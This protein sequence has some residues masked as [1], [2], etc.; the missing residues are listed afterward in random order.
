MLRSEGMKV[1]GHANERMSKSVL[2]LFIIIWILFLMLGI[3]LSS[4]KMLIIITSVMAFI[5][6]FH[7]VLRI[8]ACLTAKPDPVV[9]LE[10]SVW[11]FYMVLVPIFREAHMVEGLMQALQKIEYPINR[12]EIFMICEEK[13]PFTIA[14]VR[15]YLRPPFELIIVPPGKPQTKPRALNYALQSARG[16][17]ITI[18]DAEDSPHPKQLKIAA[19]TF[20]HNQTL[21]AIQAPLDYGN[22]DYNWLTRQ[23]ALEYCA[24]FHV[25]IPFLASA[26]LP[27]PLGGTSNHV[28]RTSLDYTQG[29][30]AYN[31]TEDA[32]LSFRLAA[33]GW[34]FGY[35][36][37]PT[38]EEATRT[39][40]SWFFQR[41]RWM[42]GFMY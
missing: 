10:P 18:Y 25:W 23:F 35:I 20:L 40:R 31:V 15:K 27:F 14:M 30:D 4:Y 5:C 1:I 13:D 38:V 21:G 28:R 26:N 32:D 37:S 16:D 2:G 3:Y 12:F 11:P 33:N 8:I 7:A 41:S 29:W 6:A 34:E 22:A 17:M 24:L 42:K 39:W 36:D 9:D 19:K